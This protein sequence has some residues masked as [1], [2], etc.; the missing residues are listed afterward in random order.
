VAP[1]RP[2]PASLRDLIREV[3]PG[4]QAARAATVGLDG[5][6]DAP[7]SERRKSGADY[8]YALRAGRIQTLDV[9]DAW[10]VGLA[11]SAVTRERWFNGTLLLFV[12]GHFA[13]FASVILNVDEQVIARERKRDLVRHVSTVALPA[14]KLGEKE[15]LKEYLDKG[16]DELAARRALDWE[17]SMLPATRID[18]AVWSLDGAQHEGLRASWLRLLSQ[19]LDLEDPTIA[20]CY[21]ASAGRVEKD[22][23]GVSFPVRASIATQAVVQK[24][25]A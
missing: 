20:S 11:G 2:R 3:L 12:C 16:L 5:R 15:L 24:L 21:L 13:E 19:P 6:L 8:L 7:E 10:W 4:G 1:P 17:R 14:R 9:N 18:R 23:P 25:S 22:A